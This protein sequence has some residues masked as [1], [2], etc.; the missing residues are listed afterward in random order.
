MPGHRRLGGEALL[1]R[2]EAARRRARACALLGRA[3]LAR[4]DVAGLPTQSILY[5][6]LQSLS[7]TIA[8]GSSQIQRNIIGERIL[9]LPEGTAL[10]RAAMDFQLSEDQ[11]AL[12]AGRALVLRRAPADRGAARARE[13][14][15][16][17]PRALAASSPRW[18]CSRCACPRARA[19][20]G[21]AAPTR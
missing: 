4:D 14:R 18:A 5:K 1:H 21:S 7:I 20:S 2:A 15:R 12:R 10:E 3:A 13:A 16:L 11:E 19:A 6:A 17:R 9:G 8:A